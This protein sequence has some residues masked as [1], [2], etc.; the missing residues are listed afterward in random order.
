MLCNTALFEP[1]KSPMEV[2]EGV[3]VRPLQGFPCRHGKQL[4]P[5]QPFV[6]FLIEGKGV[7]NL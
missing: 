4:R 7:L 5:A 6:E 3:Y 2:Q 1:F